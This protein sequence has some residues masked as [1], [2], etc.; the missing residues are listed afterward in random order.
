[1][2]CLWEDGSKQ[3]DPQRSDTCH[4]TSNTHKYCNIILPWISLHAPVSLFQCPVLYLPSKDGPQ[5]IQTLL[6][7][8]T[9]RPA[10]W[11]TKSFES[12][13]RIACWPH[14]QPSIG[15]SG[16]LKSTRKNIWLWPDSETSTLTL[17][18]S[19]LPPAPVKTENSQG[20]KSCFQQYTGWWLLWNLESFSLERTF[21]DQIES[22]SSVSSGA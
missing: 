17:S 5:G 6:R 20:S 22:T 16:S 4:F 1:M 10:H 13:K 3:V 15:L 12:Q 21:E 8:Q 19:P 18:S 11:L 2:T 7:W 9:N 14:T